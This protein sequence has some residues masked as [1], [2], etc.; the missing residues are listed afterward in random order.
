M[1]IYAG[2]RYYSGTLLDPSSDNISQYSGLVRV[3]SSRATEPLIC[4]TRAAAWLLPPAYLR[5][6][7]STYRQILIEYLR[8]MLSMGIDVEKDLW[9]RKC[10][11]T[12]DQ[13][14]DCDA[15][16]EITRFVINVEEESIGTDHSIGPELIFAF[17]FHALWIISCVE[18][19]LVA[20]LSAVIG[21]SGNVKHHYSDGITTS[22]YARLEGLWQKWIEALECNS[23]QIEDVLQEE[24][25][26]WLL[27]QDWRSVWIEQGYPS[28]C[29]D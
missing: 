26:S 27:G 19:N 4:L 23:M 18:G 1:S 7:V 25:T 5:Y 16:A 2:L 22:M 29:L 3:I 21:A 14:W 15:L 12:L 17:V 9:L 24:G 20:Y 6:P 28:W 10:I 13:G 11:T 8:M